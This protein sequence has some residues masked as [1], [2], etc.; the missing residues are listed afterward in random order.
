MDYSKHV[1]AFLLKA[2]ASFVVLYLI[3]GLA[4]GLTGWEVLL[5]TAV[6]GIIAYLLGDLVILPRTSNTIA[7][8]ADFGLSWVLIYLFIVFM[9]PIEAAFL[10][11]LLAALAVTLFEVFF[12]G[13]LKRNVFTKPGTVRKGN[14][15]YQT[16]VAEEVDTEA[17][18]RKARNRRK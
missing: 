15:R 13:Y 5:I 7:A 16:E 17:I 18:R 14:Y 9:M 2:V 1:Q 11:S 3:L 4:Y 12:H 10:P 8:I 6:L